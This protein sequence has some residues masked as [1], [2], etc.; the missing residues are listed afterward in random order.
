MFEPLNPF[1][2]AGFAQ[3]RSEWL[4]EG[5]DVSLALSPTAALLVSAETQAEKISH[6][7][8]LISFS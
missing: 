6:G 2:K 7:L 8:R 3:V 4:R 1:L 5:T